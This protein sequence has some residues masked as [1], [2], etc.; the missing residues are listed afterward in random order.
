MNGDGET[1]VH[2]A[3]RF[4]F[5]DVLEFL[6]KNGAAPETLN[7]FNSTPLIVAIQNCRL[8][9]IRVLRRF[10]VDFEAKS[11]HKLPL[12]YA[13]RLKQ[14][15]IIEYILNQDIKPATQKDAWELAR[16]T[17]EIATV[18]LSHVYNN[19]EQLTTKEQRF[20]IKFSN[21]WDLAKAVS[22]NIGRRE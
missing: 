4:G 7:I 17:P 15:E 5:K 22:E 14:K 16:K 11:S 13:V 20:L 10:K 3:C 18:L 12:L 1:A 21:P 8:N 6:L 9:C 2:L 19:F